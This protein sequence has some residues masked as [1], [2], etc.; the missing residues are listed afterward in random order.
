MT[1]RVPSKRL[2]F[3]FR[4][5][6]TKTC[7]HAAKFAY[8]HSSRL[9]GSA[10]VFV[11]ARRLVHGVS[12][13]VELVDPSSS[14]DHSILS[15]VPPKSKLRQT[16]ARPGKQAPRSPQNHQ[17]HTSHTAFFG[18]F[19]PLC[20][21]PPNLVTQLEQGRGSARLVLLSEAL[22]LPLIPRSAGSLPRLI[23]VITLL[24]KATQTDTRLLV[25]PRSG[26]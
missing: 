21:V 17:K 16:C 19:F 3:I 5:P 23:V 24:L 13:C 10:L 15:L 2:F 11:L 12:C 18:R 9:V 14:Y 25:I 4:A 7:S 26:M 20:Y 22:S 8:I 1:E 6:R